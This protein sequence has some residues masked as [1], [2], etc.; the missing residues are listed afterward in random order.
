MLKIP[1][2]Y[3]EFWKLWFDIRI[4]SINSYISVGICLNNFLVQKPGFY[5]YGYF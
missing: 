2:N 4:I 3:L 1:N 5:F